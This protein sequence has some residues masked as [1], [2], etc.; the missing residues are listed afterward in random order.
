MS[1]LSAR[2]CQ[3]E[4]CR[5][6]VVWFDHG[7]PY[8]ATGVLVLCID[9]LKVRCHCGAVSTFEREAVTGKH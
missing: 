1:G 8:P 5:E 6:P 3:S 7:K 4:G 9:P 2:R